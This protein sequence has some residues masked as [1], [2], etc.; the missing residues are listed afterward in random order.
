MSNRD[1]HSFLPN[2]PDQALVRQDCSPWIPATHPDG[3]LYFYDPERVCHFETLSLQSRLIRPLKRLFTDTD[4]HDPLSREEM[5]IFYSYL[6]KIERVE[7]L[8]IPSGNYDMVLDITL[9]EDNKMAWSY[10]YA[11]HDTR[12]LFWLDKYDITNIASELDGVESPA[13]LSASQPFTI[14]ALFSLIRQTG[15]RFESLYW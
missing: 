8:T 7:L 11:C 14:C 13:H 2:V 3:A 1:F 4:M 12:C 15:H 6:K 9:N 10:Y 5:E